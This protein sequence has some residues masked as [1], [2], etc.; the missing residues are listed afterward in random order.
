[1]LL[2]K[3]VFISYIRHKIVHNT[4]GTR[5]GPG[6]FDRTLAAKCRKTPENLFYKKKYIDL[7]NLIPYSYAK[8][9][10]FRFRSIT[11]VGE[12]T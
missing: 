3:Y 12:K 4:P 6:F 1:M 7:K 10:N 5:V 11:E 2:H 9:Q 8:I